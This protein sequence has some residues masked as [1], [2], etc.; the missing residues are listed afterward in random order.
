MNKYEY[1]IF[2]PLPSQTTLDTS[3]YE[4][5]QAHMSYMVGGTVHSIEYDTLTTEDMHEPR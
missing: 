3:L 1:T 2:H 4:C 5:L